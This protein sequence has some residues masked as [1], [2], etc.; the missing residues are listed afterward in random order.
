LRCCSI[1]KK[2]KII[3][4]GDSHT[5][6]LAHELRNS[7]GKGFEVNSYTTIDNIFMD[8]SSLG[9]YELYPLTN[10]L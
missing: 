5:G 7:L 9:N 6:G 4:I 10:G 1:V 2:R 3:I 8:I